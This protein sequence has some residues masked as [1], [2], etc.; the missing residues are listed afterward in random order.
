[1]AFDRSHW[2]FG[3]ADLSHSEPGLC[4]S[5]I[6]KDACAPW[7]RHSRVRFAPI[8]T[9]NFVPN[10]CKALGRAARL[11]VLWPMKRFD[12]AMVPVDDGRPFTEASVPGPAS[13]AVRPT[14]KASSDADLE[15]AILMPC[16]NEARTLR[17]CIGKARLFLIQSQVRGEIVLADNGSTDSSRDIASAEGAR[18]IS[19]PTRGYGAA[20]LGGI[21]AARGRYVIM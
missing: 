13:S 6:F 17:A 1:L 7:P 3:V 9:Q 8:A 5:P 15:L 16:L 12:R 11:C 19:V 2:I 10:F 14:A 21:A 4:S 18:V 20:L